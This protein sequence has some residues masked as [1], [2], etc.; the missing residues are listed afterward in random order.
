MRKLIILATALLGT[1]AISAQ[2]FS[3]TI[4]VEG[5]KTSK[6]NAIVRV[7]KQKKGFPKNESL[8]YKVIK[9]KIAHNKCIAKISLPTGIYAIAIVHDENNNNVLDKNWAGMPVESVGLSNFDKMAKPSF[10]K[11]KIH[12][13]KDLTIQIKMHSLF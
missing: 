11:S 7:F 13:E 3:A 6:G 9:C 2:D 10:D 1:Y 8:A 4:K 5:F 12:I